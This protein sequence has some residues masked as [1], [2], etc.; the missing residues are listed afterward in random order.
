[1]NATIRMLAA[2]GLLV[3]PVHAMADDMAG[4]DMN[5]A[6]SPADKAFAL[7]MKTMMKNMGAK[8]TG[9]PDKDFVT[10]MI[11]HHQGAIDMAEVELQYGK[12]P[13]LRKL[14]SDIVKAQ[15]SE[16]DE[17]KAWLAKHGN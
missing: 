1:M 6:G 17:M 8:P 3:V 14:A 12:D 15:R 5:G 10:M 4:M 16:I 11:P 2:L 7:S 9:R 13:M